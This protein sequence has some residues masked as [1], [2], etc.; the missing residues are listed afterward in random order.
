MHGVAWI[1][2]DWL[3]SFGIHGKLADNPEKTAELADMLV[4]CSVTTDNEKLSDNVKSVQ[5]HS[6]SKSCRKYGTSC[7]FGFPKLPS[8]LTM[9]A[10]PLPN[11]M[12]P[13]TKKATEKKVENILKSAKE[14]LES[15]EI[16]E[17]ID[18]DDIMDDEFYLDIDDYANR[19]GIE[20]D[21]EDVFKDES[22]VKDEDFIKEEIMDPGIKVKKKIFQ[23]WE[24]RN[25]LKLVQNTQ[26]I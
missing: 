17:E 16:K 3:K 20:E 14:L 4:S 9:I 11:D 24:L 5:K 12:D 26:E 18:S 2:L 6:H 21:D 8:K 13:D 25:F 7:R 1:D 10:K 15:D 22:A 23:R 19:S